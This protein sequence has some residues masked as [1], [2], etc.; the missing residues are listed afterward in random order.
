MKSPATGFLFSVILALTGCGDISPWGPNVALDFPVLERH[1]DADTQTVFILAEGTEADL[2]RHIGFFEASH[3]SEIEQRFRHTEC[4]MTWWTP[5]ISPSIILTR[6]TLD[7]PPTSQSETNEY[8]FIVTADEG[9]VY[10]EQRTLPTRPS[11]SAQN[12]PEISSP[13]TPR[14]VCLFFF[15][16]FSSNG[17]IAL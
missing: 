9:R 7:H 12:K 3:P 10:Y 2:N 15:N 16:F 1:W 4:E 8:E 11:P 14:V 5:A 13:I 17:F 6:S